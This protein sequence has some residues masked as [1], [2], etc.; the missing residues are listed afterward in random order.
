YDKPEADWPLVS[1]GFPNKKLQNKSKNTP[2][3][4]F[5]IAD[6]R[7]FWNYKAPKLDVVANKKVTLTVEKGTKRI[8]YFLNEIISEE[9]LISQYSSEK[10][11]C[12]TCCQE[13]DSNI[14]RTLLMSDKDEGPRLLCFHFFYP[15]WDFKLLVQKYPNMTIDKTGFSVPETIALKERSIKDMQ[16]NLDFWK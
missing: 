15:C 2:I 12:D 16:N 7:S 3:Q 10:H 8:T 14:S 1:K 4:K 6:V 9:K 13:I 11:I 5:D